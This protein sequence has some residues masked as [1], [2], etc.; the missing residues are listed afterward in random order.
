MCTQECLS[1]VLLLIAFLPG[2]FLRTTCE[3]AQMMLLTWYDREKS[4]RRQE[5]ERG[6]TVGSMKRLVDALEKHKCNSSAEF[7]RTG[8][9]CHFWK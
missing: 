8:E 1:Q 2:H 4:R 9:L 7:L 6:H 3:M 5:G